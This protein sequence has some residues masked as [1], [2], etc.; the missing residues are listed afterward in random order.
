VFT[1]QSVLLVLLG[2]LIAS[3]VVLLTAPAYRARIARLTADRV[4]TSL[5]LT[6]AEVRA[7]R[8]RIRADNAIRV[9]KLQVLLEQARL[10][11]AR[12]S[13]ELNRR[14]GLVNTL[15]SQVERLNSEN[16]EGRNA[17]H[18][19]EQ[20]IADR[21]PRVEQRLA[22]A[23]KLL[24][25][26]DRD[27][28]ALTSEATK[29]MRALDEALQIN[30]Q[31][32]QELER[33]NTVLSTRAAQNRDSLSDPKFDAEVALT[34]EIESLRARS[35]D[36]GA[37][38]AR[39]QGV[40]P[41]EAAAS[42]VTP[43]SGQT[44]GQFG[45]QS[46]VSSAL[47]SLSSS[48]T[49]PSELERLRRD[50]A[51]MEQ[52]LRA[53]TAPG[54]D[55]AGQVSHSERAK[56]DAE[57]A[58]RSHRIEDMVVEIAQLKGA[59]AAYKS[60]DPATERSIS[61]RDSKLAMKARLSS[62]QGQSDAQAESIR[63]LRAEL[64]ASNERMA[65]QA[66]HFMD[67]MRRLGAGT[68]PTSTPVAA[69]RRAHG[70]QMAQPKR[71]LAARISE[72]KPEA[73]STLSVVAGTD[74]PLGR[75]TALASDLSPGEGAASRDKV[76]S[77]MK[78]LG[79]GPPVTA[80]VA[81][82]PVIATVAAVAPVVL[83]QTGSAAMVGQNVDVQTD[84]PVSPS[85]I[86]LVAPPVFPPVKATSA[87]PADPQLPEFELPILAAM[88]DE[89]PNPELPNPELSEPPTPIPA[90]TLPVLELEPSLD[91]VAAPRPRL[92]E[93]LGATPKG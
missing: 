49:G 58:L 37:L 19:L 53:R 20:T 7:D 60:E 31:H 27:I 84:L 48:K 47:S 41:T 64:A 56:L 83:G 89:L 61:L 91:P 23:K 81:I 24:E 78:T 43:I 39:L 85:E 12:Q 54:G 5:P 90:F 33:V 59:L 25:Q 15:Q 26:R 75:P 65:R 4:R 30:T 77:L 36:Q 6:E 68:L 11:G 79:A 9:H 72:A 34:S 67:E 8:D 10:G 1:I 2:L 3:L 42:N 88:P 16:E 18:V 17:R 66:Q 71:S 62:L 45:G 22:D 21:V 50:L 38:I 40:E 74:T 92:L 87:E 93:R 80:P 52:Q 63:K 82:V 29:T 69:D 51:A 73:G 70:N 35:R 32:R 57:L 14:D 13:I 76:S 44:G 46:G 86:G 28:T 55:Q